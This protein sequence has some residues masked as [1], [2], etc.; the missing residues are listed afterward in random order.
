MR[1]QEI[2]EWRASSDG[3]GG[4]YELPVYLMQLKNNGK[5]IVAVIPTKYKKI[6][7]NPN[8]ES[9]YT[10]IEIA[11]IITEEEENG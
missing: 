7:I 1:T 11:I 10:T 6:M 2:E 9:I 8:Y 5:I 4:E 3:F